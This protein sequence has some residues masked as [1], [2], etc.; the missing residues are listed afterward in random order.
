MAGLVILTGQFY[1]KTDIFFPETGRK[2]RFPGF[3]M[4]KHPGRCNAPLMRAEKI[5]AVCEFTK[6]RFADMIVSEGKGFVRK[7]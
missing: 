3:F 2:R 4:P 6:D 5:H 7:V 1:I